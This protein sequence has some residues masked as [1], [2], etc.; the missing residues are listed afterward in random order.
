MIEWLRNDIETSL[1][2]KMRTP[3][4]FDFLHDCIF[5]RLRVMVSPTT[6][7]RIWG[8]LDEGVATRESTLTIL[9]RF[10]GYED[11]TDY[12]NRRN[13]AKESESGLVLNHR[14]SVT[15]ELE[16]GDILLLSWLPDR[17]CKV[18]YEGCGKF[19]VMESENTR[20][21]AGD[22]FECRLIIEGEPLYLDNLCQEGRSPTA[23]VCGK[24]SGVRWALN[25]KNLQIQSGM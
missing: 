7:K 21:R 11:W 22:T 12:V 9:A 10:I 20:L 16:E 14:L 17:L 25:P 19:R 5:A 6:L 13:E 3:K 8:Y 1:K 4:D 24:K 23:Y 2:R 18:G 15:E